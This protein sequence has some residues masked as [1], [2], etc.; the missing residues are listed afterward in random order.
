MAIKFSCGSCGKKFTTKNEHAGRRSK[1]PACGWEIV[2]PMPATREPDDSPALIPPRIPAVVAGAATV[3]A[4]SEP[5]A[6]KPKKGGSQRIGRCVEVGT[7]LTTNEGETTKPSDQTKVPGTQESDLVKPGRFKRKMWL[8]LGGAV[9]CF[10]L[11]LPIRDRLHPNYVYIGY[12]ARERGDFANAERNYRLA[13]EQGGNDQHM[14]VSLAGLGRTYLDLSRYGE[15][16]EALGRSA[17]YHL[18]LA[19]SQGPDS[20]WV[21]MACEV[22]EDLGMSQ[23]KQKKTVEGIKNYVSGLE[24]EQKVRGYRTG[25]EKPFFAAKVLRE[26]RE[27]QAALHWIKQAEYNALSLDSLHDPKF[28]LHEIWPKFVKELV[29]IYRESGMIQD[30]ATEFEVEMME[31]NLRAYDENAAR[32][33]SMN[34]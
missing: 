22:M 24:V 20:V 29:A 8:L 21:S 31:R 17:E 34:P 26:L 11:W 25:V 10:F 18:R 16:E 30:R 5:E 4:K 2:V 7:T 15:A 23:I 9:A 13:V 3:E 1:C 28:R 33:N 12:H 6:Q 14:A 27:F 19:K 32:K